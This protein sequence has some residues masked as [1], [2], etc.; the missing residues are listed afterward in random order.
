M[1]HACVGIK[2]ETKEMAGKFRDAV[3]Q[4]PDE[5]ELLNNY[6]WLLASNPDAAVRDGP[7][8]V[9]L[10]THACELAHYRVIAYVDTLAMAYAEAGQFDEATKNAYAA[11]QMAS[12]AGDQASMDKNR[13]ML[14]SFRVRQ[15]YYEIP[16]Q[17]AG[18]IPGQ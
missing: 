17:S 4:N 13:Q 3:K 1:L 16:G 9:R 14:E 8:A 7:E 2:A 12:K 18:A 5:P 11:L 15:P 10:A 6:A